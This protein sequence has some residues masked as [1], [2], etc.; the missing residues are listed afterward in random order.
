MVKILDG[1]NV[2]E[3]MNYGLLKDLRV[4]LKD[5]DTEEN[6]AFCF[7]FWLYLANYGSPL[8]CG[9]LHQEHIDIN[10][11]VPFLLLNE[12]KKMMLLPVIFLHKEASM[13]VGLNPLTEVPSVVTQFDI[14]LKKWVHVG[15]EASQNSLRLR[16]NGEIVGE[17]HL[18]PVLN[19]ELHADGMK[20]RALPCIIGE[21]QG[22]QGYVH[23]A[24]LSPSGLPLKTHCIEDPPLQLSID[25]SS[26]SDIEEDSDGIWSIVGGKAS[27]RRNFSLDVTL[28][29]AFDQPLIKEMEVVASLLYAD[30]NEPVPETNDGE[31]PLLTSYDGIEYASSDRPSK[32]I[33]GRASFKLKMSQLSSK[34]D[35][36]LFRIRFEIPK[37]RYPFLEAFSPPI[38]CISR[39]RNARASSITLKKLPSGVHLLNG[40]Q[41]PGLDDRSS[42]LLNSV[43]R[44]AKPSPSSKRVKLGQEKPFEIFADSFTSKRA[45]KEC[46]SYAFTTTEG[47]HTYGSNLVRKPENHDGSDNFSSDSETSETTKSDLMSI[48]SSTNQLSDMVV[49]KYCLG[50]LSERAVLLKEIALSAREEELVK[51]ADQVSLFSGCSHHRHQIMIAKRLIEEGIEAWN[52]ISQKND[53]VLWENLLSGVKEHFM[54]IVPCG[55]RSLTHQDL[56]LLRRISGCQE[57]VSQDHFE[58]MWFWLY[59]VAL[60]LSQVWINALWSSASPKWIEGFITKEEAESSLQGPGGFQ[61][62]GTFVLR[63]PTSRSWPHPDAG[64][65]VI[66]YIGS[67]Y[68][69]HHRLL[70]LD[71]MYSS[72]DRTVRP[73][74]DM[75]LEEPELSRLGRIQRIH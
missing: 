4:E 7:S 50:G 73:L 15:C 25:S 51:F 2:L 22:F 33:S 31:A 61:E 43:V 1:A 3:E 47:N 32:L 26:A 23:F 12:K 27:C 40:S 36:R 45:D 58:K 8:P 67:D 65:L 70:S 75:L 57:L 72:R 29:D 41:S 55:T 53:H 35:N 62:P 37:I 52:L 21:Y 24:K 68:A 66:T 64:N 39:S 60:S 14:P 10:S 49:F 13:L 9:I 18:S 46:K 19:D 48:P 28:L 20:R 16:V 30:N 44:E 17:K 5:S 38:R 71:L 59:P 63:F 6:G 42:E 69:I 74:Q 34:C 56:E 54:K 11:S